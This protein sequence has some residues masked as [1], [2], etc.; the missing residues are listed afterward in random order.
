MGRQKRGGCHP[1]KQLAGTWTQAHS[2][3]P[4]TTLPP[5]TKCGT[6]WCQPSFHLESHFSL[7]GRDH[8]SQCRLKS[9]L[10]SQKVGVAFE[11]MA[12]RPQS[13][14]ISTAAW[15]PLCIVCPQ[16]ARFSSGSRN[17]TLRMLKLQNPLPE[18]RKTKWNKVYQQPTCRNAPSKQQATVTDSAIASAVVQE[19]LREPVPVCDCR[20][21]HSTSAV[22]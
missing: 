8:V 20:L 7:G 6:S 9:K 1:A 10:N 4:A 22:Q 17:H 2:P 12:P 3:F 21:S 5:G 19:E 16:H 14:R 18:H 11:N 13:S 15:W